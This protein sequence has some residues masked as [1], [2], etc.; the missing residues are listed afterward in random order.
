M[1]IDFVE[2]V[3]HALSA[4][5]FSLMAFF[6]FLVKDMLSLDNDSSLN[7]LK[8]SIVVNHECG[9]SLTRVQYVLKICIVPL[10]GRDIKRIWRNSVSKCLWTLHWAV[11]QVQYMYNENSLTLKLHHVHIKWSCRR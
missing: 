7:L 6:W 2:H 9:N 4:G 11:E 10:S 1:F 3:N 8:T 5:G